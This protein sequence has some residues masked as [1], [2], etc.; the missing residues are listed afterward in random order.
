[1]TD[2]PMPNPIPEA[3]KEAALCEYNNGLQYPICTKDL[4]RFHLTALQAIARLLWKYGWREPVDPDV[5]AVKRILRAWEG[6]P[7]HVNIDCPALDRAVAVYKDLRELER[8]G[9]DG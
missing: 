3:L 6:R 9:N 1:M 7:L 2:T 8:Q 5:E 4:E